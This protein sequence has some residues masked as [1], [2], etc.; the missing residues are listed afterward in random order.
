M[1]QKKKILAFDHEHEQVSITRFS[2][3][4]YMSTLNWL[5][6]NARRFDRDIFQVL[7]V[8]LFFLTEVQVEFAIFEAK[9]SECAP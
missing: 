8:V 1:V 5:K 4:M 3:L 9:L 6:I 2:S 7:I